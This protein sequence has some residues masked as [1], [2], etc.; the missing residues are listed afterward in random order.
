LVV[1]VLVAMAFLI[2]RIPHFWLIVLAAIMLA[3]AIDSPVTRMRQRGI[4]R[5]LGVLAI[6]TLLIGFLTAALLVLAPGGGRRCPS[7]GA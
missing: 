6:F 5:P 2:C 7:A 3:T 1:I 4:S